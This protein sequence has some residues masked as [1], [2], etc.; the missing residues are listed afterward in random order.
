VNGVK[1]L[2]R[3]RI[4]FLVE[5]VGVPGEPMSKQDYW[6]MWRRQQ[7]IMV[8]LSIDVIISAGWVVKRIF[9]GG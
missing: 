2:E 7:I 1:A 9:F 3:Q 6:D 5:E 4:K 8:L